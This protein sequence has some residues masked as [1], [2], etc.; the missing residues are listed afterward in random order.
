MIKRFFNYLGNNVLFF[1]AK[2]N[3]PDGFIAYGIEI[4]WDVW[5]Q[6]VNKIMVSYALPG[7]SDQKS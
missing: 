5:K 6:K 4:K 2:R 7:N 3:K 1:Q